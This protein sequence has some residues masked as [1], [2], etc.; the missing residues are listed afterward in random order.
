MSIV[1]LSSIQTPSSNVVTLRLSGAPTNLKGEFV[2]SGPIQLCP[3]APSFTVTL[4]TSG[5]DP[6]PQPLNATIVDFACDGFHYDGKEM[7]CPLASLCN[8]DGSITLTSQMQL[9]QF[10]KFGLIVSVGE[11]RYFFDPQATNDPR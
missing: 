7:K 1:H 10:I 9:N 8:D 11:K 6:S 5:I 4:D 2:P 3:Q